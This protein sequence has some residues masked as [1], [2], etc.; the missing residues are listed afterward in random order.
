MRETAKSA[1]PHPPHFIFASDFLCIGV[2]GVGVSFPKAVEGH[3]NASWTAVRSLITPPGLSAIIFIAEE[4]IGIFN[5]FS[6]FCND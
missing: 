6:V 4:I 5:I 2:R 3:I 1:I